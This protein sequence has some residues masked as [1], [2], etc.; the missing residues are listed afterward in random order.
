MKN[1]LVFGA[2][3]SKNSINKKLASFTASLMSNANVNLIDLN[4]F[5]MPIFNVDRESE[6]GYPKLA[7]DFSKLIGESDGVI[8]SLAE[9]NGTY[10]AAFKNILD[11]S[12]RINAGKLWQNTPMLVLSTSPGGRGGATVIGL[13]TSHWKFMAANIV[14]QFSLPFFNDNFSENGIT[15]EDMLKAL[16]SELAKFEAAI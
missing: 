15:D 5:E 9:H 11:W 6:N 1:I 8:V 16:K 2:S 13:A 3:T 7:H 14:G 4:N 12:S 10:T